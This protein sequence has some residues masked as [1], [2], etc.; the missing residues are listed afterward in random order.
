MNGLSWAAWFLAAIL[1]A[2][3]P[4][5][6]TASTAG[7]IDVTVLDPSG[8]AVGGAQVTVSNRVTGFNRTAQTQADGTAR[9][10]NIAPNQ[11]HLEVSAAGLQTHAEDVAVRASVPISL[12]ITLPLATSTT[13]VEVHSDIGDL[14]ESV[15]T[16]HV[17]I[18]RSL[19]AELPQKA[20]GQGISDVIT[21]AAPGI[22]ADSN[23]MF[24]PL[25]DHAETSYSIDNQPITDQQSKQFS[26]QMPLNIIQSFEVIAGAAPAEYGDKAG[27]V[28]N[29]VTRSGLGSPKPFGDLHLGYGSFGTPG[30]SGSVG[31]GGPHFGEFL[32]FNGSRS[33]RYLDS[34]E[35]TPLHD[36][37]NNQ[38]VFNRVDI[39][40]DEND[41]MHLNVF[42]ARTWFQIPNTWDQEF[43]GQD[44]RQRLLTYNIAP[45][46]VHTFNAKTILTFN[47]YIRQ[48]Q[49][50]Y[51]PSREPFSDLPA[52]VSQNRRLFNL[53][54]K[55]DVSRVSGKHNIK[56]G[57]QAQRY[58]LNES[59]QLGITDPGFNPV[60]L[61]GSA[62]PAPG[63]APGG[64]SL[65]GSL[66]LP[67]NPD[68]I[69]GLLPFDLTRGG[70]PFTFSGRHTVDQLAA[71]L[72]DSITIG[73][74]TASLGLRYD[75]YN[76]LTRD[77]G[78]QPRVGLSY[79]FKPTATVLRMSY[80]R[81]F[82]T[83]YNENLIL[84]SST[85]SGGLAGVNLGGYG[86]SPLKPGRRD[87]YGVGL[88]QGFLKHL[89]LDGE[90]FWKFTHNAFDFDTLFNSPIQFPIE[91]RKSKIDGVALRLNLASVRGFSAY[92][93]IG[94]TRAR[95]FGPENGG[96]VFNSPINNSVFRIDHDQAFEQTT[97]LRYQRGKDGW[98][99]SW[100]WRYD[101]GM[102]AGNVPDM[103]SAL[104][105]TPY[106]QTAIGLYCGSQVATP[107]TP[108]TSCPA[109]QPFG[110]ELIRI[111]AE[112]TVN[113]DHNPPRIAPRNLFDIAAGNDNLF[114]SK[115]SRR[116]TLQFTVVNLTN[117][118][119]LYNFLSTFSGTHFVPPRSYR[120]E[121]GFSF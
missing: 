50:G 43:A 83:P 33:G 6:Q 19:F 12:K 95:F 27:L 49:V 101:S 63:V 51:Y 111:P 67:P 106:E 96:I 117:K 92:T 90:Y 7:T 53:G 37:G 1:A 93:V 108:I 29:A 5:P 85:G 86:V 110:A 32:A 45:G 119:A 36:I 99:G 41:T 79:L 57:I 73:G 13:E 94:H 70:Q 34:P 31:W 18:D 52:T 82:E 87:Q 97:S 118:V 74:L 81:F 21:L 59:F 65:C 103:E 114:H 47:P 4:E 105:L 9:L 61:G 69:P 39:Q 115:D 25:G 102:V 91:W 112:G 121:I 35:F 20:P 120:A 60:C 54:M 42:L 107:S 84:S 58:Y 78:W 3:S 40:P 10:V 16:A 116:W 75:W 66:G 46:W 22:T 72:Q 23:G 55:T 100:T 89:L 71:F 104:A 26:N 77:A 15:P 64:T 62:A 88:Q 76:G 44:Q 48:D 2:D 68:F 113:A 80:S 11:Y 24:H 14:V 56:A 17:D 38:Q 28:V 98:W 30:V 8:A 109:G